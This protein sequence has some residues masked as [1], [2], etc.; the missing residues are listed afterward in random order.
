MACNCFG[1]GA[2]HLCFARKNIRGKELCR[3]E[4]GVVVR[5]SWARQCGHSWVGQPGHSV[6]ARVC[7]A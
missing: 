5:S 2:L 3:P 7:D 1:C 6:D 4:R